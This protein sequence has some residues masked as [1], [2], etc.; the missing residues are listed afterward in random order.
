M[1]NESAPFSQCSGLSVQTRPTVVFIT[2]NNV[3]SRLT[4][5]WGGHAAIASTFSLQLHNS[6]RVCCVL[7]S[8]CACVR[9]CV[10]VCMKIARPQ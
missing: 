3:S 5:V 8:E 2:V 4:L 9:V 7:C 6:T 10:C 1:M